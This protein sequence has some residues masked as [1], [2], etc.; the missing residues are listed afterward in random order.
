MG[1]KQGACCCALWQ[2]SELQTHLVASIGAILAAQ[3]KVTGGFPGGFEIEKQT[4]TNQYPSYVK[5]ESKVVRKVVLT[6]DCDNLCW[7]ALRGLF[8][9]LFF[10]RESYIKLL[11][12]R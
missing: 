9:K 7:L 6:V 2:V 5:I 10:W 11:Y 12:S 4:N 1:A 8:G 3:Q